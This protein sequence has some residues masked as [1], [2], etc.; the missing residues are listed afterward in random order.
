MS[1]LPLFRT[2]KTAENRFDPDAEIVLLTGNVV[3]RINQVPDNS[4]SLIITSPPDNLGKEDE[5]RVSIEQ[6]LQTQAQ[7]IVQQRLLAYFNGTLSYR[8]LEK[9]VYQPSGREKISQIS[10]EWQQQT[11][12]ARSLEEQGEY[13]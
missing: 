2:F 11:A 13:K 1:D 5:N 10:E 3:E 12:Q 7:V 8:P 6:Y 4:I 9:P